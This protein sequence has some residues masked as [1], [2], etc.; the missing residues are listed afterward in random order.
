M[1]SGLD[2]WIYWHFDYNYDKLK[3]PQS[4]AAQDLIRSS[5]DYEHLL[6]CMTDLVLI[7]E[8][9]TSSASIVC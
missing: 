8:L 6:F 2:D 7:Y 9:V 5:L 1:G 3:Q 4:L